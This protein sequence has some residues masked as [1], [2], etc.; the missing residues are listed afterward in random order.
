MQYENADRDWR[1]TTTTQGKLRTDC[2]FQKLKEAKKRFSLGSSGRS[3]AL[4]TF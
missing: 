1:D 3:V 2:S 4:A